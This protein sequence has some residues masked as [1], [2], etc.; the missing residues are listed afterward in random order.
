M[1]VYYHRVGTKQE[2]D[3]LLFEYPEMPD[4]MVAAHPTH[5]GD[6][7]LITINKGNDGKILLFYADLND[8]ENKSLDKKLA[9]KPVVKEWI[10]SYDYIH[11]VGKEFWF[12]TDYNSPL[13]KV[14]KFNIEEPAF[15][16]WVD[17]IPEH[18]KNVLQ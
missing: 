6:Y 12:Q 7:L 1:K 3:V 2:K 9:V 11:N 15:E 14:V 10:A 18:P 8:P 5:E 4:A 13:N 16:N 17:V